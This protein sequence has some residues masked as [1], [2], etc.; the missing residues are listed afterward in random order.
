HQIFAAQY[1]RWR[2]P[3]TMVTSGGLVPGYNGIWSTPAAIG[4][5]KIL[6]PDCLVVDI[7]G[8]TSF[9]MTMMELS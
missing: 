8:Y 5:A 2:Y 1:F 6:L 3:G 7:D 9:N 4:A